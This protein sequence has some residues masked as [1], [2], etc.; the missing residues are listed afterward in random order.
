MRIVNLQAENFQILRAVE[1]SPDGDLV[2]IRGE[3]EQGK[4]SVLNAIWVALAGRAV[5]P[6]VP[7]RKGEEQCHLRVDLGEL[8]VTRTFTNK[9]GGTFTD[10]VKVESQDGRQRYSKPQQVL[11]ELM[12][13]IGFDPFAFVQLKPDAQAEMLLEMVPLPIDLE[14]MARFDES[15]FANRRDINREVAA[16]KP[17]I[18]AIPP[19]D[20][21]E[22]PRDKTEIANRLASAA[23]TNTAIGRE[24]F[25]REQEAAEIERIRAD[26]QRERDGIEELRRR[27]EEAEARAES[28]DKAAAARQE[29]L[30]KR[31]P[32]AEPVDTAALR[33]EL[34][35]AEEE[36]ALIERQRRRATLVETHDA[37]VKESEAF[38]AAISKREED[39]RAALAKAK[40]PIEGLAFAV[41][42]KGKA[43]VTFNGVPFEQASTAQQIKA[44]VA[45]AMATNPELRVLR[46]KDGSLL[47]K[48]SMAIIAA[49]AKDHDYQIWVEVV[50]SEGV[51]I[52]IEDG[53]VKGA[54]APEAK[55]KKP[56]KA[57]ADKPDGALI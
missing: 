54:P 35:R 45:I 8:V 43:L 21:P 20:I 30:D 37:K 38:T 14:E 1:I 31:E 22:K 29:E 3:N 33:D 2:V 50:G 57:A 4:S 10:T 25:A 26:A 19:E 24:R 34:A 23:D 6:P 52:V 44:S 42:E 17:L 56:A 36:Q 11:D 27:I 28:A 12:G 7:V 5:A 18:S 49:M 47:D 39:R 40:M 46:I 13:Q 51:G 32:I 15:D 16:L 41:N 53:A 9:E 48:N 55:A